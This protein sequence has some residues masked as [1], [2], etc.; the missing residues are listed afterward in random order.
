M[1]KKKKKKYKKVYLLQP[2]NGT[3]FK[4]KKKKKKNKRKKQNKKKKQTKKKNKKKKNKKNG[5]CCID[6][7]SSWS[8]SFIFSTERVLLMWVIEYQTKLTQKRKMVEFINIYCQNFRGLNS[9]EK[10]RLYC[11]TLEIRNMI[12]FVFRIYI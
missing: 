10:E 4:K 6:I 5:R 2:I 8:I 3:P 11:T 12:L 1:F 7:F 9:M